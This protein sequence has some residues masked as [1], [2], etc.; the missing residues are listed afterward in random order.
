LAFALLFL[1]ERRRKEKGIL[2]VGGIIDVHPI[3]SVLGIVDMLDMSTHLEA[4]QRQA[5]VSASPSP[6][7]TESSAAA[8]VDSLLGVGRVRKGCPPSPTS[9]QR[10][11]RWSLDEKLLFLYGLKKYGKGRWKKISVYLPRRYVRSLHETDLSSQSLSSFAITHP[12]PRMP[13][14]QI[15]GPDQESRTKG[16][17]AL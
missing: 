16:N 13:R 17:E 2:L 3:L 14:P 7:P 6:V 15:V 1:S 11:G 12:L 8:M 5:T 9:D 4:Q 10:T